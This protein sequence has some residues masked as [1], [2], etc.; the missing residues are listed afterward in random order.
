MTLRDDVRSLAEVQGRASQAEGT[1]NANAVRSEE[2]RK[3]ASDSQICVAR[4]ELVCV[5]HP[6]Y[7]T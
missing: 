7:G 5:F 1:A 3:C 2:C 4:A 6:A